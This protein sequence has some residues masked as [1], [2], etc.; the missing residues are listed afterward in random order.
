MVSEKGKGPSVKYPRLLFSFFGSL[1]RP[2]KIDHVSVVVA[3]SPY[4]SLT[5]LTTRLPLKNIYPMPHAGR[6]ILDHCDIVPP[7]QTSH[8][9]SFHTTRV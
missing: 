9:A 6:D 1:V 4:P 5:S 2:N 3:A 7:S 8:P